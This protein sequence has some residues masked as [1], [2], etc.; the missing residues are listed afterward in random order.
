MDIL[1][2]V[3]EG[4]GFSPFSLHPIV[5]SGYLGIVFREC[6]DMGLTTLTFEALNNSRAGVVVHV[7]RRV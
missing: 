4:L 6:V 3:H 2:P 1:V 5:N 7:H